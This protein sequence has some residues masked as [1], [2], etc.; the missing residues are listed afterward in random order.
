[1]LQF[2]VEYVAPAVAVLAVL[3]WF[4]FQIVV[5]ARGPILLCWRCSGKLIRNARRRGPERFLPAFISPRRCERCAAR[6]YSLISVNYPLRQESRKQEEE[7]EPLAPRWKPV[8][9]SH[10]PLKK[11]K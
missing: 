3:I 9:S 10:P 2:M 5:I 4:V 11:V 6:F 1:M 8:F 7:A